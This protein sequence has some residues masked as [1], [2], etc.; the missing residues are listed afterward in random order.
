MSAPTSDT[1][2][3]GLACTVRDCG[4][5]LH[6]DAQRWC[7]RNGHSF[8]IAR[9]GYVNLLQPQDRRSLQAGDSADAVTARAELLARG[10]GRA[11][12]DDLREVIASLASD[13]RHQERG[14]S[15]M[16]RAAREQSKSRRVPGTARRS[17]TVELGSGTG[18]LLQDLA[19]DTDAAY[20]GIDLSTAAADHA[21]RNTPP[22]LRPR[23]T[24]V[25][26]NADRRLPL[27]DGAASLVLSVHGRRNAPEVARILAPG[28]HWLVAVPGDDDLA[29][30][31]AVL[32]GGASEPGRGAA[33][34]TELTEGAGTP[35]AFTLVRRGTSRA[36]HPVD[37]GTLDALCRA[38]YRG[39]RRGEAARLAAQPAGSESCVTL[40]SD[41]LLLRRE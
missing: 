10:L 18:A 23:C 29:E 25:V 40:H 41:W 11:L 32:H 35:R 26:A 7:C 31:R 17:P 9:R 36:R 13:V 12:F 27:V 21:A 3:L 22:E 34:L 30:L 16:A 39:L 5:P 8:D 19:R 1:S 33:L 37:K 20:I 2:P 15:S 38:T 28:G 24:W 6:R 4:A 14:D